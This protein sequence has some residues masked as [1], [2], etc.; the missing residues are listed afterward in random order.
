MR[1]AEV[2]RVCG[3]ALPAGDY[4]T[5]GG[6]AMDRIGRIPT[7]GDSFGDGAWTIRVRQMV[8]LRVGEVE[9]TIDA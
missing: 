2:L 7:V 4:D 6:L 5:V 3:V 8:G 9:L 1:P